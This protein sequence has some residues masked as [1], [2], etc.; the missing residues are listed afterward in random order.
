MRTRV[1]R[2]SPMF[3]PIE[4]PIVSELQIRRGVLDIAIHGSLDEKS[5]KALSLFNLGQMVG[6]TLAGLPEKFE[7]GTPNIT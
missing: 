7:A 4:E 1:N 3:S 5:L 6:Y 2:R